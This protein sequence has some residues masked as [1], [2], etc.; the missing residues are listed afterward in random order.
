[1][2]VYLSPS[3][4]SIPPSHTPHL[5]ML[6]K[7][8][9]CDYGRC[10]HPTLIHTLAHAITHIQLVCACSLL[11][12][13]YTCRYGHWPLPPRKTGH[14]TLANYVCITHAHAHTPPP[15]IKKKKPSTQ[16]LCKTHSKQCMYTP[17]PSSQTPHLRMLTPN[18]A[19]HM[20]LWTLPPPRPAK[21]V[22]TTPV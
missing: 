8:Y 18:Q 5:R 7:A 16:H 20:S 19:I 11:T 4:S 21:T 17:P 6:I 3:S 22:H 15:F 2:Y 13:P 12:K 14:T 10:P 9:I 1:M